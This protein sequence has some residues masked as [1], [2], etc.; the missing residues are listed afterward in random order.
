MLNRPIMCKSDLN[1]FL[2]RSKTMRRG[3]NHESN[4]LRGDYVRA[5]TGCVSRK[6]VQLIAP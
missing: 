6:Q 4:F 1:I 2:T 5:R 3:G